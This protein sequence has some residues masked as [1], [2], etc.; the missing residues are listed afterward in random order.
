M[1]QLGIIRNPQQSPQACQP[2]F[3]YYEFPM[4]SISVEVNGTRI[5]S[6]SLAELQVVSVSVHG[7]L[8]SEQKTVLDAMGG[9]YEDGACGHLIWLA[10]RALLTGDVVRIA[11]SE[12]SGIADRGRTMEELYPDEEP[13]TRTDFSIS[14]EMAAEMR[15]RPRLHD[16]FIVQ[17]ETSLA[18]RVTA[19]SDERNTQFTFGLLWNWMEPGQARIRL[20]TLC[21]DDVLAR[22]GGNEHL[23]TMIGYGEHAS[24]FLVQ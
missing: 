21:L 8:D 15:A 20:S 19:A 11:F 9:N 4:P 17:A 1:R 16:A 13:C 24:F 23:Q 2:I 3:F 14:D 10:E 5:A 7:R 6:I 18:Q 22:T 12:S